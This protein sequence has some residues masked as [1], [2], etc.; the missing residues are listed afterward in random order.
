M[1]M[2]LKR[3]LN[4]LHNKIPIK[5]IEL[6]LYDKFYIIESGNDIICRNII[7]INKNTNQIELKIYIPNDYPFRS[8]VVN[9][10]IYD[11]SNSFIRE[12]RYDS[13]SSN[14]IKFYDDNTEISLAWVF[15][16]I[17][18]PELIKYW[19]NTMPEKKMCLC[20]KGIT[21]SNNWYPSLTMADILAEYVIRKEFSI[22]K[23]KLHM[24]II[25][26]I[27]NNDNWIIP[28][29]IIFYICKF[30]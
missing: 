29:D 24:K 2:S 22:N 27:F 12:E 20:C 1:A 26:R 23:K 18:R 10:C 15:S 7:V 25:H 16:N 3:I 4:E 6:N 11:M 13:W 8:P 30:L 5:L 14:I 19:Y 9:I 17:R 28:H 21:C